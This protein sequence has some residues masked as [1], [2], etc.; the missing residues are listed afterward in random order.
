MKTKLTNRQKALL[1]LLC[2]EIIFV[3]LFLIGNGKKLL[4]KVP[5]LPYGKTFSAEELL[6]NIGERQD[7]RITISAYGEANPVFTYGP[8]CP[9]KKG[10]YIVTV[11]Y[12]CD[13]DGNSIQSHSETLSNSLRYKKT[14]DKNKTEE[15]L[16]VHI[17]KAIPDFELYTVY[18]GQGNFTIEQVTIEQEGILSENNQT[19]NII[20][21]IF[22]L[23]VFALL[24][25]FVLFVK[26]ENLPYYMLLFMAALFL[27][28]P[29]FAL[30]QTDGHDLSIHIGRIYGIRD[31][32]LNGELFIK[33]QMNWL[34]DHGCAFGLFYGDA[35]LYIPAVLNICGMTME[36]AYKSYVFLANL[37][38]LVICF[39]CLK[40]IYDK[41]ISLFG[42][43]L[44]SA[45]L[46]RITDIYVR[47]AVGEYSAL[48]FFPLVI[49]GFYK[50]FHKQKYGW[51]LLSVGCWGLLN[52]HVLSCEMAFIFAVLFLL[53][54]V[55]LLDEEIV[56]NGVFSILGTLA[57]SAGFCVPFLESMLTENVI[58]TD[59]GRNNFLLQERGLLLNQLFDA[60]PNTKGTAPN[61]WWESAET[62]GLG[63]GMHLMLGI[64]LAA[65]VFF[66][67]ENKK[68]LRTLLLYT[69]FSVLSLWMSTV[70]FPW[71][72]IRRVP[73][74][75]NAVS[76]IQFPWRF[77]SVAGV[78]L[79]FVICESLRLLKKYR[80]DDVKSIAAVIGCICLVSSSFYL[81]NTG[82]R[83]DFLAVNSKSELNFMKT[84]GEYVPKGMELGLL[85][86]DYELKSGTAEISSYVKNGTDIRMNV[87]AKGK[88]RI[89]LPLTYYR[90]YTAESDV[91]IAVEPSENQ[92]VQ[93][94]VPEGKH[95]IHV[96]YKTPF[97]WKLSYV[98]STVSFL[99][100][101]GWLIVR[102][103]S[104]VWIYGKKGK[105][106]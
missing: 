43:V 31:G 17:P 72:T 14:L 103:C 50:I 30:N 88:S 89:K 93:I 27:S 42:S 70:Y 44:Y 84:G 15:T 95:E 76:S 53:C 51:I 73:Y 8:G 61:I 26:K 100:L 54:A 68:E 4:G 37:A 18:S 3:G 41:K 19:A 10:D 56:K 48:M 22:Y 82:R 62:M 6:T 64:V 55:F 39:L 77:M 34:K 74:L 96:F 57:L 60:F 102:Q 35:L 94:T 85:E 52:T 23:I 83:T 86:A 7:G 91:P 5:D 36:Y 58:V 1:L 81:S 87:E 99:L 78:M 67:V 32:L 90:H 69:S 24:D 21:L 66:I 106:N 80:P 104:G 25:C 105:K 71:D 79:T 49:V 63:T 101:I 16:A 97:Y 12:S 33:I 28:S 65:A 45:S 20:K 47:Q 92:E 59:A 38:T 98:I 11:R 46:Y 9:L 40:E 29:L 13:S 2:A 75:E